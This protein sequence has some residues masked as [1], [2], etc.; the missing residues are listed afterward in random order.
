[1]GWLALNF[2]WARA[3]SRATR[4]SRDALLSSVYTSVVQYDDTLAP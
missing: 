2:G 3:W 1:M 4:L